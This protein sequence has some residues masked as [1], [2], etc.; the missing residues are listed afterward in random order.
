MFHASNMKT[1]K[2]SKE[3]V[4][5]T[6]TDITIDERLVRNGNEKDKYI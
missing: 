4:K 2:E 5:N 1:L 6:S 3:E